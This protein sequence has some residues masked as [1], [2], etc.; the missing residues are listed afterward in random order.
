MIVIFRRKNT[1]MILE[2]RIPL[3]YWIKLIYWD[4]CI[5]LIFSSLIPFLHYFKVPISISTL[6]G[7]AIA[8]LL[9]FKLNQSYERWWEA[10]QI[11]GNIVND[12]RTLVMQLQSFLLGKESHLLKTISYRQIAWCYSL[13]QSL[14]EDDPT[15]N[16]NAYLSSIELESIKNKDHIPL[17]LLNNHSK[18]ISNLHK[19]NHINNFQQI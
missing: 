9:S 1:I 19:N 6:L 10:R 16:I 7:T 4:F 12:S 8:L 14:R 5:V 11:W 3:K 2:K 13:N 17:S 15:K 18:D